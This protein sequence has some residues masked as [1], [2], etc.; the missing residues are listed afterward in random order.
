MAQSAEKSIFLN[1]LDFEGVEEREHYL[2]SAC[3]EDISLR[4]SVQALLVA[5]DQT[6]NPLD[7]PFVKEGSLKLNSLDATSEVN[8][9]ESTD[10]IGKTIGSYRLMEQIGEGGFGLVYAAFQERPV[11]RKVALKVIKPGTGSAEVLARFDAERQAIAMM[12]HPSIAQVFD[13]GVTTDA[14]PYFVM[15]LVRGVPITEFCQRSGLS[16]Q[17]KIDL[18]ADVCGAVHHAHQK[19]VIHRDLKPS[20]VL[21]TLHDTKPVAKVIDFGVAKAMGQNLTDQTIYTRLYSMIGTPLYMSPE[22]AS[23]SGLDVD[24]RSDIYSLGV[25][26]YELLTGTTPFDRKRLDTAGYDEMRRIIQEEDPPKPSVRLTTVDKARGPTLGDSES[27]SR[28]I[29][30]ASEQTQ[31]KQDSIPSDLDW[32]VMKAMEKDRIRR[33]ESAAAMAADLRRFLAEEPIE[34]RPPSQIYRLTKF[35]RRQRLV[36]ATAVLMTL[37]L[38]IGS[39]ASLYQASVAINERNQKEDALRDAIKSKN[40]AT[41]ARLEVEQFTGR[42]KDANALIGSARNDEEAE[43]WDAAF[44][45]YSQAVELVPNYYLVWVQR[46]KLMIDLKL[47]DDAASDYASAIQLDAPLDG[48]QWQ[49]VPALFAWTQRWEDLVAIR[50]TMLQ[51][52]LDDPEAITWSLIRGCVVTPD[53]QIDFGR[54]ADRAEALL[55]TNNVRGGRGPGDRFGEHPSGRS[56]QDVFDRVPPHP[57][58]AEQPASTG[59]HF[60]EQ[61]PVREGPAGNRLPRTNPSFGNPRG[62]FAGGGS[63]GPP[64]S[65]ERFGPSDPSGVATPERGDFGGRGPGG[66]GRPGSRGGTIGRSGPSGRSRAEFLPRAIKHYVTGWA[67][68]RAGNFERAIEHL[69]LAGQDRQWPDS[70]LVHGLVAIAQYKLGEEELAMDS[71]ARAD[72]AVDRVMSRLEPAPKSIRLWFDFVERLLV[73]REATQLITGSLPRVDARMIAVQQDARALLNAATSSA[74]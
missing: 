30:D 48:P 64:R 14:R 49:G 17:Q 66:R 27:V 47:W 32:I 33:Y 44:D 67:Q 51:P 25:M 26:L 58:R 31:S 42:L 9:T 73:H 11:R 72:Q 8:P 18:F 54:L 21:V 23:M 19:G 6:L 38:L 5:H 57:P 15:E 39:V 24:T 16:L 37:T 71:L 56:S 68:L 40:E 52:T 29:G 36:I 28:M 60:A 22:Q 74:F 45:G 1:A 34:A 3:G 35:A 2:Q 43:R 65:G 53:E 50:S 55:A 59:Q 70:D 63:G 13:A 10:E 41:A 62:G 69:Q 20:N 61:G 46:A 12:D 4:D 7:E